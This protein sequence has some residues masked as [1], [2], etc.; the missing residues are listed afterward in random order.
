M[1]K[2][3]ASVGLVALGAS[4]AQVLHAGGIESPASKPYS[5]SAT[6]RG[7]FD[8]NPN[9]VNDSARD[10]SGNKI[11]T[12]T[13]GFQL[14]PAAT[15]NWAAEQTA[16]NLGYVFSWKH[17]DHDFANSHDRDDYSHTFNAG[18]DHTFSERLKLS[19]NDSFVIGQ[20]PDTLRAGNTFSTFQRV[21]GNNVRNYGAIDL[22]AQ[23]TDL[24]GMD[25]GYANALYDYHQDGTGS[26]SA[27][28][29]RIEHRAHV[30]GTFKLAPET[31]AR[32]GYE[33][34]L[35]NY[36][37][38]EVA[39]P[40]SGLMSSDR[41]VR[42][43]KGYAGLDHNFNPEFSTKIRAGVVDADFYNDPNKASDKISPYV[44]ASLRY[45]YMVRSYVEAG[46][47]YD[48]TA[49]DIIDARD[50]EAAVLFAALSHEIVPHLIGR[51]DAQF[52]NDTINGGTFN[53]DVERFY[54]FGL[55]L[56]YEFNQYLAAE[57]GYN[58]DK[59]SSDL[60]AQKRSFDRNRAYVG[61]IA[62]Y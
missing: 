35:V 26:L 23:F 12:D 60:P 3:V 52:Q 18:L 10:L 41:N 4:T 58:F 51:I 36:T 55:N 27:V 24:L 11:K 22:T 30:D 39:D 61:L 2:I 54:L 50:Q 37:A 1:N 53:N 25:V 43:H 38:D 31:T 57:V 13:F 59:L 34:D 17:Y 56:K 15:F 8:D 20:E 33:F 6:L 7:F 29:D 28:L 9:T 44:L 48:R 5:L 46:F 19:V 40:V 16:V 21:S 14:S 62:S 45:N 47:S 42:M 49:T 32:L